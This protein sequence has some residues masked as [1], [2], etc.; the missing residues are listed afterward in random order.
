MIKFWLT[1]WFV[2]WFSLTR[3]SGPS[4]SISRDVRPCGCLMSPSHATMIKF[5]LNS[6]VIWW[7]HLKKS[8]FSLFTPN[9]SPSLQPLTN[10]RP[11]YCFDNPVTFSETRGKK[12][13]ISDPFFIYTKF[14][15]EE[16]CGWT[17][18][19]SFPDWLFA[20]FLAKKEVPPM[21][22]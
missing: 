3:P 22:Y 11:K 16:K 18:S 20:E 5:L 17:K 21:L 15:W 19:I 7:W 4:L 12:W 8:I 10:T 9:K 14:W 2:W 1:S 13:C 6:W